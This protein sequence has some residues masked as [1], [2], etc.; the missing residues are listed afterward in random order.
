VV[1]VQMEI[2]RIVRFVYV[3]V[4]SMEVDVLR[5]S[6]CCLSVVPGYLCTVELGHRLGMRIKK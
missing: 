5:S 2:V 3:V 1:C 6:E 4:V